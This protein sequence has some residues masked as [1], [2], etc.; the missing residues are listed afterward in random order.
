LLHLPDDVVSQEF[1]EQLPNDEWEY[2]TSM[3]RNEMFIIGL[4]QEDVKNAI[5]EN[6]YKLLNMHLYRTNAIA[7]KN[8]QFRHHIETK[9]DD[10]YNGVKNEMQSKQ[11][12]KLIIIQSLD[13]WKTRNPI[14]V[15]VTNLGRI[16]LL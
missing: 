10:K 8:Y 2:V 11:L 16:Q 15:S 6:N 1:K 12:G 3:Q 5:A 4:G 9:V 13:A 14:K 7:T